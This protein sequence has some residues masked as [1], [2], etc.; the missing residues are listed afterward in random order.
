MGKIEANFI[1]YDYK[2]IINE[3]GRPDKVDIHEIIS[4]NL[5]NEE[6]NIPLTYR[7]VNVPAVFGYNYPMPEGMKAGQ[8]TQKTLKNLINTGYLDDDVL[9]YLRDELGLDVKFVVKK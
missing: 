8:E 3:D 1:P 5:S 7:T 2:D 6:L 4:C 9:L